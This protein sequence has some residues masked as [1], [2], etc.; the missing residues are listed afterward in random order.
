MISIRIYIRLNYYLWIG[1]F[2]KVYLP[3]LPV[4]EHMKKEFLLIFIVDVF[5]KVS[6]DVFLSPPFRSK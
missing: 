6:E 3:G 4:S 2:G 1:I 5:V